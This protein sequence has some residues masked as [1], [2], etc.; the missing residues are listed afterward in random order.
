[1]NFSDL[2]KQDE[3]ALLDLVRRDGN[4]DALGVLINRHQGIVADVMLSYGK[5]ARITGTLMED[6]LAD[7]PMVIYGAAKKYDTDRKKTKF[8]T[9]LWDASRFYT[10]NY[11]R[12]EGKNWK[13]K[14]DDGEEF[15]RNESVDPE[16]ANHAE[17]ESEQMEFVLKEIENCSDHRIQELFRMRYL[18]ASG[19]KMTFS[20]LGQ[21]LG[22]SCQGAC[23]LHDKFVA[24]CK[25]K[26]EEQR[27]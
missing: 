25:K 27:N 23:F 3:P 21:R 1:M 12:K 10:F 6:L 17:M 16:I 13:G 5:R 2:I 4:S 22:L 26:L 20:E 19:T 15:L 8:S 18:N 9:W 11:L 7:I 24:A 14:I